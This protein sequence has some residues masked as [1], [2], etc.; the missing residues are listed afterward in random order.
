MA[1]AAGVCFFSKWKS[2]GRGAGFPRLA[3]AVVFG[4]LE[5]G[6]LGLKTFVPET[7]PGEGVP[8][9]VAGAGN[10]AAVAG[11][12]APSAAEWVPGLGP[13]PQGVRA[14]AAFDF[15]SSAASAFG[16][17][18]W[19]LAGGGSSDT[20]FSDPS[21]DGKAP[22]SGDKTPF[23]GFGVAGVAGLSGVLYSS[24]RPGF[25]APGIPYSFGIP[26]SGFEA[27]GDPGPSGAPCPSPCSDFEASG[28]PGPSGAPCP[29]PD[30]GFEAPGARVFRKASA[31]APEMELEALWTG[32]PRACRRAINS[33]LVLPICLDN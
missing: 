9:A 3:V 7:A 5:P 23:R 26:C 12:T 18:L 17:F 28:D 33:L 8:E 10:G 29:S 6:A 16:P 21:L 2:G 27:P 30:S 1:S 19:S 22:S 4:T 32:R 24:L 14:S 25:E 11:G 13:S 20:A 15:G 31:S